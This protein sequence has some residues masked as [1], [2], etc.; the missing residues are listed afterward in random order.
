MN[1]AV[2]LLIAASSV[3][4]LPPEADVEAKRFDRITFLPVQKGS[5]DDEKFALDIEY[6]YADAQRQYEVDVAH[7]DALAN[8]YGSALDM[9]LLATTRTVHVAM[10]MVGS[11]KG[12]MVGRGWVVASAPCTTTAHEPDGPDHPLRVDLFLPV[13][14]CL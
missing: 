9:E 1:Y 8:L 11:D 13:A 3:S 2:L 5:A 12:D 7:F 4:S 14:D 6:C 10:C